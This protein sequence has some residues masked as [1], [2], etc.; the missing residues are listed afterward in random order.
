MSKKNVPAQINIA[1]FLQQVV[2]AAIKK[3]NDPS[4]TTDVLWAGT[5]ITLPA[6]PEPMPYRTAIQVLVDREAADN[7]EYRLFERIPG[8]PLDAAHAFVCML[9]KRYG[10]AAAKTKQTIFGPI[11]PKMQ[12]VKTG[13]GADDYV[14][15]PVGVF[16]LHDINSEIETGFTDPAED[17]KSQFMDFYI[18]STVNFADRAV[19]MD[20]ISETRDYLANNSIYKG[21]ALRL[22]VNGSQ[23]DS[24]VQPIFIDPSKVDTNALTLN[25]DV[26][27]LLDVNLM[28]PIRR[29]EACRKN[30]IQLKRGI[31]L[32]GPYGT[33][34][35]LT[36]LVTAKVAHDNGWTFVMVDKADALAA[37][38]EFA[39]Q[40][41]PC[42]VF[43]EDID[44]IID[45]KRTDAANDIINTIDG[46]LDKNA[47][48][49][50]VLTTNHLEKLPAV[51]LRNGRL[52]AII[53]I[54][55]PDAK[56]CERLVRYYSGDLLDASTD[57]GSLGERM[58]AQ[59]F[60][61]A[62]VHELVK[63]SK[64]SM[65]MEDRSKL[66]AKDLHTSAFALQAHAALLQEQAPEPSV[67]EKAGLALK[68]LLGGK[69]V[70]DSAELRG[71]I[72]D[73]DSNVDT[74]NSKLRTVQEQNG[75]MLNL[76]KR[77]AE[78]GPER[79]PIVEKVLNELTEKV[80]EVNSRAKLIE[81]R[82]ANRR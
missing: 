68:A 70:D 77:F 54:G 45:K 57:L 26:Q 59:G 29:T 63:R 50:T 38:L 12:M 46:M 62:T 74:A 51:M 36:A 14:E 53:P 79:D 15:V 65:L 60:I 39:R 41:Q 35:T 31:L 42:V 3:A 58:V 30:N 80:G 56:A 10:W 22:T 18:A 52:D 27:N 24:L 2:D 5:T 23:L 75:M 71:Q 72:A 76:I 64:L 61:S 82:V 78:K 34:K 49:I 19:I 47:E 21:K 69:T 67:A 73:V 37:T 25:D 66:E 48:V 11:P 8:M 44:R 4:D 1:E 40:F 17:K 81:Q 9:K 20:L 32:E 16:K 7:Q 33:G 13:P 55:K 6:E 28:T 43:A